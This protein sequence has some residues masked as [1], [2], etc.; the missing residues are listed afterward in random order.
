MPLFV[1]QPVDD[2]D[3]SC[4]KLHCSAL[5]PRVLPLWIITLRQRPS[6]SEGLC[7][8]D[9]VTVKRLTAAGN[10]GFF[11][12][13]VYV[14]FSVLKFLQIIFLTFAFASLTNFSQSNKSSWSYI[15]VIFFP[16]KWDGHPQEIVFHIGFES[17]CIFDIRTIPRFQ[18]FDDQ[19]KAA[20]PSSVS[21]QIH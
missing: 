21:V 13:V 5:V 7:Y 3:Y 20:V 15:Q 10:W 2:D 6:F 19:R 14:V 1:N 18:G 17:S 12:F 9:I 4:V 16:P 11:F 8:S